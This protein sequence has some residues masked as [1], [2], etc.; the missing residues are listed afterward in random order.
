MKISF[1]IYYPTVWGQTLHVTGSIPELGD[2]DTQQALA[3]QYSENSIWTGSIDVSNAID[4][5][6]YAYF[7]QSNGKIVEEPWSRKRKAVFN[8]PDSQYTLYDIWQEKPEQMAFYSSAF[9]DVLFN[10]E[11]QVVQFPNLNPRGKNIRIK[12]F[13][14]NI[15][16]HRNLALSGNQAVLG[17]WDSDKALKMSCPNYP[18]WE[19]DFDASNLSYPVEYKFIVYNNNESSVDWENG[20]NRLLKLPLLKDNE[21]AIISGMTYRSKNTRWKGAGMVIPVFSLRSEDSFGIGDFGDLKKMVNWVKMTGQKVIQ[22][23][24]INDTTMTHT[25]MDSYPYNAISIYALHPLYLN[26]WEMGELNDTDLHEEF[27][28]KQ[29]ELNALD[30]VDYEEV[31]KHKWSFFKALF[32][33]EGAEI[34]SSKGF[35]Q[36]FQENEY[37]LVPYA[38]YSHLREK[39]N[40]SD[41][42]QWGECAVYDAQKIS[43]LCHPESEHYPEISIYYYLQYHLH[44][45]LKAV[46]DYAQKQQVILKGDIPIGVSDTSIEAW[47]EPRY[48]NMNA[49]A[50]APP[51]DFST[52]GQN[53]GFPTYNWEAMEKDNYRWWKNRFRHLAQYFD[54]YRID[55][56]LGFFRIW[57]VPKHSVQ[58]LYAYFNPAIS[59]KQEEIEQAGLRFDFN[60]FTQAQIHGNF[61]S[62]LF[63]AY[64]TEATEL[65]LTR[66]SKCYFALKEEFSTQ[67][68]IKSHFEGKDDFKSQTIKTALFAI[69]EEVLFIPDSK[70]EDGYYHPSIAA[71][72]TFAY[73]E[74]SQQEKQA[75]DYLYWDYFY[76]RQN[77]F[78]KKQAYQKLTPLIS[79]TKMLVCGE[80]LGMIPACVPEVMDDLQIMSLEIERMPKQVNREFGD[81]ENN[82]YRSVCTPST[83][84]M[85]TIRGWWEEDREKTQRY[86]NQVLN[87]T[88]TAPESCTAEICAQIIKNHL[89]SPSMLVIIPLQD[90]LSMDANIRRA[91]AAEERI[92]IPA[93]PRHYWGYRMHLNIEELFQAGELNQSIKTMIQRAG[94]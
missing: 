80:D 15:E 63:G 3:L 51:D 35:K 19:V 76:H 75:F 11:S 22:T 40:T 81:T 74:L 44:I 71:N 2:G 27:K 56:I 17:N 5:I 53:W 48:F 10:R 52:T 62:K 46:K 92:N 66:I 36:F 43:T 93:N 45:Q 8:I 33:Q 24:P 78:W 67:Q 14:P 58:A 39:H 13:A 18:E 50:G 9:T 59:L 94:R 1:T 4:A 29:S 7:I 60:K 87:R 12:V 41:F 30:K 21:T 89:S 79:C 90:W 69:A 25:W 65:Y 68:K 77:N 54:A 64:A 6:E 47:T 85:S 61:L 20:E 16:S 31:D 23:L 42:R 55:H 83:H 32:E 72:K 37:W 57:E 70:Q 28:K 73:S 91:H 49:Q 88:G 26:L 82:P 84:D 34:L 86:F 38:A